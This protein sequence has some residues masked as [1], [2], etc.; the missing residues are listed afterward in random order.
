ME[1]VRNQPDSNE[2]KFEHCVQPGTRM[3]DALMALF[4]KGHKG[5]GRSKGARNRIAYKLIEALE[6][7]FQEHGEE[8]VKIARIERPVEYLKII[9]SVIPKEFE[10]IDGR[11]NEL[12][13]EELDVF[14]AKLR[15]Q[16]RSSVVADA[17]SGE[18]PQTHH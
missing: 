1:C 11:L 8:A 12:S 18:D 17:G 10:I 3:G 5:P 6:K 2:A 16:L 13:D 4:E 14:I 9:A 15:G 7:D